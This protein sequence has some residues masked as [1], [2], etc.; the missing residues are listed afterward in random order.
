MKI[1]PKCTPRWDIW[2]FEQ[3]NW[4]DAERCYGKA[5]EADP[6]HAAARYN[7]GLVQ[8][9]QSKFEE[10]AGSFEQAAQLDPK[11]AGRRKPGGACV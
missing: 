4:E 11:R 3:Q 7:L 8:E 6:S 2:K 10:A 5:A 1:R 9:R